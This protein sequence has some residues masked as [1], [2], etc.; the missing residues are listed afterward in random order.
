MNTLTCTRKWRRHEFKCFLLGW[1]ATEAHLDLSKEF[2]V[3][4]WQLLCTCLVTSEMFPC[5]LHAQLHQIYIFKCKSPLQPFSQTWHH[6][7]SLKKNSQARPVCLAI[8]VRACVVL[9]LWEEKNNR[10]TK[11]STL[12][13][14]FLAHFTVN[15]I[16]SFLVDLWSVELFISL[17]SPVVSGTQLQDSA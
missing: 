12:V 6:L 16:C 8:A 4:L 9:D 14:V 15:G 5:V 13:E 11:Y 7:R 3:V 10:C 17:Y 1:A 2:H